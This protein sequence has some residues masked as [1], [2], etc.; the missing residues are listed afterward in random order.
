MQIVWTVAAVYDKVGCYDSLMRFMHILARC[1]ANSI[2]FVSHLTSLHD[3]ADIRI[4]TLSCYSSFHC[5][6][7][8]KLPWYS[9]SLSIP[10]SG[11]EAYWIIEKILGN[12]KITPSGLHGV[13][14]LISIRIHQLKV[15]IC[16][17]PNE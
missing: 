8:N 2:K 16:I 17:K 7:S 9:I 12:I 5:V 11:K 6:F 13:R 4:C 10:V 15:H 1:I 3:H 14:K